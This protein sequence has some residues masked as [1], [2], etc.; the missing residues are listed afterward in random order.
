MGSCGAGPRHGIH[1]V[2]VLLVSL[3][4]VCRIIHLSHD[5]V[6]LFVKRSVVE[7]H[8]SKPLNKAPV[9]NRRYVAHIASRV[10]SRFMGFVAIRDTILEKPPVG[11]I[12]VIFIIAIPISE[13]V[14]I[15]RHSEDILWNTNPTITRTTPV[16][17]DDPFFF[18]QSIKSKVLFS[19]FF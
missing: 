18:G 16:T 11:S 17:N 9:I 6:P 3:F 10:I 1:N 7:I 12:S 5:V 19:P 4:P 13:V 15:A 2:D 14:H 8:R